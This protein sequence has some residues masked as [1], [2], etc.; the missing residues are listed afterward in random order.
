MS[1]CSTASS[2]ATPSRGHGLAKRV[3]VDDHEID[4]RNVEL[5][6][7]RLVFV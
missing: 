4:G 2:R 1:I 7:L 5:G 6:Q 3:E